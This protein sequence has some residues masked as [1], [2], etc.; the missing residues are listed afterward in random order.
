MNK[1]FKIIVFQLICITSINSQN[2]GIGAKWIYYQ[3][4]FNPST[5]NEDERVIEIISDTLIDNKL[6]YVL[7]GNCE[8]SSNQSL[9][10]RWENN[11]I[12]Q[13]IDSSERL[14]YDFNLNAGDSL[15]AP[16][17]INDTILSTLVII[18]STEIINGLKYQHVTIDQY[19]QNYQH[20]DWF[21]P[22]VQGIGSI[23]FCLTPQANLCENGTGGLCSF[24]SSD[25]DTLVF[26]EAF[27][28]LTNSTF[29]INSTKIEVKPNPSTIYWSVT[30]ISKFVKY[31]LFDASGKEV[32]NGNIQNQ[33][34]IQI[35]ASI[36]KMGTYMLTLI[37]RE[38]DYVCKKLLKQ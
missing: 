25:Q 35:D 37:S 13:F 4:W 1:Y 2:I 28:C 3:G 22:F 16:I 20:T 10:L 26:P 19:D 5:G 7:S 21:G 17:P 18:D 23:N 9:I 32:R 14:L 27:N 6:F 29:E 33:N 38:G 30:N 15:I 12:L 31:Y 36:L 11:Q 34:D 8:C 24:I